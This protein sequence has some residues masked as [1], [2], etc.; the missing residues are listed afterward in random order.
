MRREIYKDLLNQISI[1]E[2]E[3]LDNNS[4]SKVLYE[5]ANSQN[6]ATYYSRANG[7]S[8]EQIGIQSKSYLLQIDNRDGKYLAV[9]K[10]N[11]KYVEA[12]EEGFLDLLKNNF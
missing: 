5:I 9:I 6:H 3:N 1:E 10:G 7:F 2:F 8:F 11:G 4:K 12:Y